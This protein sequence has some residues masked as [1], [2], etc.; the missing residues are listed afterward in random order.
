MMRSAI[1]ENTEAEVGKRER[2]EKRGR[3]LQAQ[4]DT[5][6]K[7]LSARSQRVA[8]EKQEL[9]T[10]RSRCKRVA[11]DAGGQPG[12][13][14][15]QVLRGQATGRSE[16]GVENGGPAAARQDHGAQEHQTPSK[17][18]STLRRRLHH[19]RRALAIAEAIRTAHVSRNQVPALFL[20]FAHFF[21][22]KLP[23]H[24]CK[25]QHKVIDGKTTHVEKKLLCILGQD[26]RQGG[27][28][29]AEAGAQALGRHATA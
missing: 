13:V 24:R 4:V 29:D 23:T 10:L 16:R 27:L 17:A 14:Q 9:I 18:K 8:A 15:P 7:E 6:Q 20:I 21:R 11:E 5:Q 3:E 12:K 2:A 19:G 1:K 22:I 28:R 25:V 26:A